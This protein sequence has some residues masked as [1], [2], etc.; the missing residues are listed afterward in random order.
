MPPPGFPRPRGSPAAGA[1]PARSPI[2]PGPASD[3][4]PPPPVPSS[5]G[6]RPGP[7]PRHEEA[8][9]EEAFPGEGSGGGRRREGAGRAGL[10]G[11]RAGHPCWARGWGRWS[12]AC[13]T[14]AAEGRRPGALRGLLRPRSRADP[15][16]GS[17]A[18][19]QQL[20]KAP[21]A[22]LGVERP[23]ASLPPCLF[24]SLSNPGPC[25]AFPCPPLWSL[26]SSRALESN[27]LGSAQSSVNPP[28]PALPSAYPGLLPAFDQL[29]PF[30]GSCL[31]PSSSSPPA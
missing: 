26:P 20:R 21:V 12:R 19:P 24:L 29:W 1:A 15:P 11:E 3:S 4:A 18:I 10:P 5:P 30:E 2:A 13:P 9:G 31:C 7:L 17:P 16:P 14:P 25:P 6:C 22:A 23:L 8:V 28:S 27:T